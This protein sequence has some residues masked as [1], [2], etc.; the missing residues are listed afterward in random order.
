[1][2]VWKSGQV[3]GRGPSR[4][5][6]ALVASI[7]SRVECS[8]GVSTVITY[9]GTC[10]NTRIMPS[11]VTT[12]RHAGWW[13]HS[14]FRAA[15]GRAI[16]GHTRSSEVVRSH[17][18]SSEVIRGHQRSSEVIRGHQRSSEFIRVHLRSSVVIRGH[19]QAR[20]V[21]PS[22]PLPFEIDLRVEPFLGEFGDV[23]AHIVRTRDSDEWEG[24]V[25]PLVCM[26][27]IK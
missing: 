24:L 14:R 11:G 10:S 17:Q 16:R 4:T 23:Q 8:C 27:H 19:L 13:A 5:I 1:M 20:D 9:S 6:C 18:R 2:H 21:D 3:S 15:C 25:R 12:A 7:C 22:L 26:H